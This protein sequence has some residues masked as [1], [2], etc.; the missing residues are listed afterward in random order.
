[1]ITTADVDVCDADPGH[2][3]TVAVTASLRSLIEVWRGD[4]GWSDALRSGGLEVRGPERLRR[5]M[6]TWFRKP[7]MATVPRTVKS[8]VATSRST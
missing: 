5:A 8:L 4:V 7:A 6:P 3:V 1:M 2:E